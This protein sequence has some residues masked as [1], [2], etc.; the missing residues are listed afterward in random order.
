MDETEYIDLS[1]QYNQLQI[2]CEDLE[3]KIY[4]CKDPEA[5]KL[6]RADYR[7]TVQQKEDIYEQLIAVKQ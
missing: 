1:K 4:R 7:E 6:L 3:D 2:T 5:I